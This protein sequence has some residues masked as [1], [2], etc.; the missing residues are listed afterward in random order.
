[1]AEILSSLGVHWM[2]L[3]AQAVN[4]AIL[5][6]VLYKWVIKPALI[7]LDARVKKQEEVEQS[8]TNISAQ[9]HEIAESKN[10]IIAEARTE[11]KKLIAETEKSAKELGNKLK[12]EA[13]AEAHKILTEAKKKIEEERE[14]LYKD[15]KKD[16][17]TLV[18]IGIEKT[19]GKYIDSS[20][21][22]KITEDA[23]KEISS[24]SNK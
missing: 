2:S 4:F 19:V 5:A 15:I 7:S 3:L 13:E 6:F 16:I 22:T 9:L 14:I 23:V 21:Q 11:S 18:A 20:V 8:A 17:A 12:A 24:L 1:M 10:A